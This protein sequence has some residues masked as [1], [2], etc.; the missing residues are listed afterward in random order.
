MSTTIPTINDA[1][2]DLM[3]VAIAKPECI[4]ID[5]M[6]DAS[7]D[8]I[9]VCV[10]PREFEVTPTMTAAQFEQ[11]RLFRSYVKLASGNALQRLQKTKTDLMLLIEH[12]QEVAA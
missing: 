1:I 3:F 4:D 10:Y 9:D 6:Y 7:A 12:Q 2:N 11:A 8:A 5:V